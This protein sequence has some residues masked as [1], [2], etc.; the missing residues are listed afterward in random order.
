M[1][2]LS[3]QGTVGTSAAALIASSL[4]GSNGSRALVR[5]RGTVAVYLGAVGVTTGTGFQLD[6][7]ESASFYMDGAETL[8]AISGSAAQRVDYLLG[9]VD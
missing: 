5:N 3:G 8:Y 2:F 1:A 7:G 4:T 6:P 9:G